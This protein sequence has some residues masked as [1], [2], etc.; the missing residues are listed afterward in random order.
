M[1]VTVLRSCP[2]GK[3]ASR[4]PDRRERDGAAI[5]DRRHGHGVGSICK[6]RGKL[7]TESAVLPKPAAGTLQT[8]LALFTPPPVSEALPLFAGLLV[9][10]VAAMV[11]R[12]GHDGGPV[13]DRC[14]MLT[15]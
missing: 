8:T 5:G 2:D 6:R 4:L 11:H 10:P 15:G 12:A 7:K 14:P 9:E 1:E 3:S 13:Y